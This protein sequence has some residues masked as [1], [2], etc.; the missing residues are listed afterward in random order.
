MDEIIRGRRDDYELRK[1]RVRIDDFN[2]KE[3]FGMSELKAG[4]I[5]WIVDDLVVREDELWLAETNPEQGVG[6][7]LGVKARRLSA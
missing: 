2:Y 1:I 6:G 3:V 7:V 5:F 4:D